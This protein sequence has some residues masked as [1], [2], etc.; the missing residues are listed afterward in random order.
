VL[1]GGVYFNLV[2]EPSQEVGWKKDSP[3]GKIG[4]NTPNPMPG[5]ATH[6]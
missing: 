5:G 2:G 1:R 4:K 6:D 3:S